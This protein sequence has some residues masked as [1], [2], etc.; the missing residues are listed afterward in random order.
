[1]GLKISLS[2]ALMVALLAGGSA[3]TDRAN[4]L[5][6]RTQK[7]QC[8]CACLGSAEAY[9]SGKIIESATSCST[10]N[11]KACSFTTRNSSGATITI[12]GK[13][14]LCGNADGSRSR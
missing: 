2:A 6:K 4:A 10:L 9:S 5:P 3:V 12:A 1:M 8:T 14:D 11:G 13:Y 7:F